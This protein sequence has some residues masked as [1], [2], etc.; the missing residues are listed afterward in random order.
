MLEY[1]DARTA[2]LKRLGIEVLR[3]PNELFKQ[4]AELVADS[5][6]WAVERALTRRF[7]PPSPAMREREE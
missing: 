4:D 7:A 5:I 1:D 2:V 3:I 6:K